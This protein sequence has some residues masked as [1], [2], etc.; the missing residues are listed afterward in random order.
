MEA[1]GRNF[2]EYLENGSTDFYQTFVIFRQSS[3]VAF[4]NKRVKT[5]NLLMAWQPNNE[6]VLG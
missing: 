1:H 3:V 5:G 2:A 4:E 6:G